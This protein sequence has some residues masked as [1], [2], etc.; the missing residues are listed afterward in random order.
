[1]NR[2][3]II[4]DD[5]T[6]AA[7]AAGAF[8]ARG[9]TTIL[10]LDDNGLPDAGSADVVALSTD[11]RRRSVDDAADRTR[12][13]AKQVSA[14]VDLGAPCSIY[15]KID[16][17]LR[18]HPGPELAAVMEAL[19]IDR[20]LIAP[21]FPAQGRTVIGGCLL[22]DGV[23]L[24]RTDFAPAR[25]EPG[26]VAGSDLAARFAVGP[27][28]IRM[29]SIDVVRSDSAAL[30][31][32]LQ[33]PGIVIADAAWED[34]LRS[35][36]RRALQAKIPLCCGSAGLAR[37][38]AEAMPHSSIPPPLIHT[39]RSGPILVVAASRHP[40]TVRQI[41]AAVRH[42]AG[43]PLLIE[44]DPDQIAHP[45]LEHG[46]TLDAILTGL[47]EGRTVVLSV[48]RTGDARATP[49]AIVRGLGLLTHAIAQTVSLGGLIVTGGDA[50]LGVVSALGASA[51]QVL[52]EVEPGIP[53]GMSLGGDADGLPIVTKAGGFG[54][55][56]TL[57]AAIDYLSHLTRWS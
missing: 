6:G 27:S 49:P 28:A 5:L 40:R 20:A 14:T 30:L 31:S 42:G 39:K 18:G 16:S 32:T 44:P 48:S 1:M 35:L 47:S 54:R 11:S 34:D 43:G 33:A 46:S 22:I 8:A 29:A 10:V 13:A 55:E 4:A 52:G 23:P 25:L 41:D 2:L 37:A 51:I 19:G 3:A 21:A 15:K 57:T 24:E 17:T 12:R 7:D 50:A 38:L 56:E 45:R 36:A 53:W 26:P 9:L